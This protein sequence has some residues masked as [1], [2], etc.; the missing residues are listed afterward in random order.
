M[1]RRTSTHWYIG[2]WI[3]WMAGMVGFWIAY[4]Q[5]DTTAQPWFQNPNLTGIASIVQAAMVVMFVSWMGA[6]VGLVRRR[7]WRW[8]AVVLVTQVVGAGI[9]GMVTYAGSGPQDEGDVTKPQ[10]T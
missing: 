3:V 2:A 4:R 1:T 10:V 5:V 8:F 7:Q 9:A 6:L